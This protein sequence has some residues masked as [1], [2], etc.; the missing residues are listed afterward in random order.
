LDRIDR[1]AEIR[2]LSAQYGEPVRRCS[3]LDVTQATHQWWS[4]NKARRR[5]GEVVLFIQRRNGNLV[6]HTKDFYPDRVMRVPSGGIKRGEAVIGAV[7]REVL[8]ET[9]LHVAVERFF[10]VVEFDFHWRDQVIPYPSYS[11][12]LREQEGDLKSSDPDER[13]VALAEVPFSELPAIARRLENVPAAWQDWG[14]FRAIP[15]RLVAELMSL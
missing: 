15:H 2:Q 13:I 4:T 5:D 11:F 8:E 7:H 12:L 9:G 1:E 10:A 3:T 6:L 14:Q